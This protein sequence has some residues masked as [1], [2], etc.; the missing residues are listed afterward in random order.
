MRFNQKWL[1]MLLILA[2]LLWLNLRLNYILYDSVEDVPFQNDFEEKFKSKISRIRYKDINCRLI[3]LNNTQE[4]QNARNIL[5]KFKS[6]KKFTSLLNDSNFIFENNKCNLFRKIRK[7]DSLNIE[8]DELDFPIAY[9]ILTYNN[10]EQFERLLRAI[11]RPQNYYCIHV[12]F[13]SDP[14]FKKAIQSIAGCFDNVFIAS[15]LERIVYAGFNRLKADINCMNDLIE[16]SKN[17]KYLLNLA[18]TEFPLRTNFELVK[19]LT[20]YNGSNDIEILK[21]M[22][23][24]RIKYKWKVVR[25]SSEERLI[26]TKIEKTDPPH[27]FTIVKGVAYCAF[28]REFVDYV[29][30]D[31]FVKDLLEWGQDTY[32]PDEWFWATLQ[33]NTKLFP[34]SSLKDIKGDVRTLTRFIGWASNR[35]NCGGFW[36][37]GV[38][39]YS[40]KDLPVLKEKPQFFANKFLLE[41]DPISYQCMEE[42]YETK[43]LQSEFK[44]LDFYCNFI[45]QYN[46]NIN[47][48]L[49]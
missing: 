26:S 40:F 3:F 31:K 19:I 33:Y 1:L 39:T 36:R 16:R 45:S 5:D 48:S 9:S 27:N 13:K 37:R 35:Y 42:W 21:R 4:I 49:K 29:V 12:D 2:S 25:G 20:I 38:C 30:H 15:K 7:Y 11:Y 46:I 17:W 34:Q 41:Y 18:S 43:T 6:N 23:K 47:C 44:N 28:S 22:R 14:I 32:S 24:N 8:K 10:V